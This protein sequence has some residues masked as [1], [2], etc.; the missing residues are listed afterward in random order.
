MS[1]PTHR[2]G[3]TLIELLVVI[4]IIAIL[5]GMLLP[6]INLVRNQAQQANCGNN[7][8]QITLAMSAY[9]NDNDGLWPFYQVNGATTAIAG[10]PVAVTI[11]GAHF[12]TMA[13]FEFLSASLGN[14]LPGKTFACPSNASVRPTTPP[15]ALAWGNATNAPT[16]NAAIGTAGNAQAYAYDWTAPSN[17]S[18]SRVILADR[19]KTLGSAT[20]A[21]ETNHKK[22][23]IA[24]FADG[25]YETLNITLTAHGDTTNSTVYQD[26]TAAAVSVSTYTVNR[27]V[28]T[29]ENIYDAGPSGTEAATFTANS[30]NTS[31]AWVR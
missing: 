31:R 18:S 12:A 4:S 13:S 23:S 9:A 14:E 17:S 8:K 28:G 1:T 26:Q 25:H 5:A 6:A 2:Q 21:G 15:A 10:T 11:A 27:N 3:F 30:G 29:N 20:A 16:W 24:A 22:K 19:P 7:L